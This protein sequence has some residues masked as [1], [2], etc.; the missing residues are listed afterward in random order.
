VRISKYLGICLLVLLPAWVTAQFATFPIESRK[1]STP[2]NPAARTK[3]EPLPLSL[4]FWDDF[5]F[6]TNDYPEESLWFKSRQV[7][8]SSEQAINP[9]SINVATFD[10]LN[11]NG[12]PYTQNP[13]DI[14]D[15][16]YR[17]T[18]ESQPIKMTEVGL[19]QRNSVFLSFYYQCG[20]NGEPPDPNDFLR[21][22]FKSITGWKSVLTLN[23]NT[24]EFNPTIFYNTFIRINQEEYYHDDFQF[25][26]ISFG[27]KS[28]RYDA[29]HIDYVYLNKERDENDTSFPDRAITTKLGP[30]F[31]KY[32][33]IPKRHLSNSKLITQT[34]FE[35]YNLRD[36]D[37]TIA[38]YLLSGD[39]S[40]YIDGNRTN[41]NSE[42][43][44]I[45]TVPG[46]DGKIPP[47]TRIQVL[48]NS[49]PD[50]Y[51]SNQFNFDSDSISIKLKIKLFTGDVI[52]ITDG[53]PAEDYKPIYSPID[54][55]AND[56]TS[57][58]YFVNDYYAY[59]DGTAEYA[60]G[61]TQA[62]NQLAYFFDFKNTEKDTINGVMVH[63]P[64]FA[65]VA[66]N[67]MEF[68]VIANNGGVPGDVLY[69]Q[70]IPVVRKANNEFVEVDL[71]E[72]VE[73]TGSFFIGYREPA[74]GRVRIG[75]DK[76][77]DTGERM[78]Y[79]NSSTSDWI[80]NDRVVGNLM[81]RPRFGKTDVVTSL[82]EIEKQ[83]SVYPNP[84]NGAFY[85][86]GTPTLIQV[87]S[88]TGQPAEF[89]VENLQDRLLV[90]MNN[91]RPG[92]YFVRYQH[93][94]K[95]VVVKILIR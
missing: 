87:Y 80:Q 48:I 10:G 67:T 43:G 89:N 17:D 41:Y 45:T 27:R 23:V 56:T 75:L 73:V 25:R 22:E 61:L 81:I 32:F 29:W 34:S 38:D 65:G 33:S 79:R 63:Y 53:T 59:D 13:N 58:V 68:Y 24:N 8:V 16:G 3:A 47:L 21:V 82:P 36:G 83:V 69:E 5:S 35:L 37:P 57:Q 28:G 30:I 46:I 50:P 64:F 72:G 9:P 14:L 74:T 92:I 54:F 20:G 60:A 15:F 2:S 51:N 26:F 31:D 93:G 49:T 90:N 7:L 11:E 18:L 55:R 1:Q 39:F 42:L 78:F 62:G 44:E 19:A 6:A 77:H 12:T 71:F 91:A 76:S 84:S 95:Q 94:I 86:T 4:P 66:P 88:I 85:I 52:D 40:S 70:L